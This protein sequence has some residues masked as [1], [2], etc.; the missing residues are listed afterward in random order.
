MLVV[1]ALV[2]KFSETFGPYLLKKIKKIILKIGDRSVNAVSKIEKVA[3]TLEQFEVKMLLKQGLSVLILKIN[4][5]SF[6]KKGTYSDYVT[7]F[8]Q[9]GYIALF[10]AV[11]PWIS[12]AAL[13]NNIMELK[14]DAFKYC[15]VYTRPFPR[16]AFGIGPWYIAFELLS[17]VAVATNL[18]LIAVHPDVRNY[19]SDY[20][21]KEY[22]MLFVIAEVNYNFLLNYLRES[23]LRLFFYVL[24]KAFNHNN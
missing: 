23:I 19:F 15:H 22:L 7:V 14:S 1:N 10:S 3:Y 18:S 17:F 21:D 13:A 16:V 9:Y 4:V 5:F 6:I 20:N 24:I 2:N 8:E 12:I 11:F